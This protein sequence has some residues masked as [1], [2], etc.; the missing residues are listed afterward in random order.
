MKE[1]KA[2]RTAAILTPITTVLYLVVDWG[3]FSGSIFYLRV[4]MK[5]CQASAVLAIKPRII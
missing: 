2:K 1:I 3:V 4:P 5:I